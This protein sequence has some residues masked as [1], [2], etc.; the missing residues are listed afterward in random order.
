ML[1]IFVPNPVSVFQDVGSQIKEIVKMEPDVLG[2]YSSS[3][4]ILAKEKKIKQIEGLNPKFLIGASELIDDNSRE[5]I[6]DVF[7]VPLFDQYVCIELERISWQ[8]KEKKYYHMDVDSLIIEF[9]NDNENVSVGESG[10]I[11]CTS[12]FN[13]SMPLIRYA[14][15]DIGAQVDD[16]CPC[17]RTLPLMK[18]IEGRRDSLIILPNG[19]VVSP[20]TFTVAMSMFKHYHRFDQFRIIQR[21]LD[22][23]DIYVKLKDDDFRDIV[24]KD[25]ENFFRNT[26]FFDLES[27]QFNINFVD[28]IP[29]ERTGKLMMVKSEVIK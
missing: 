17:E 7:N 25:F 24:E 12:L 19:K 4:Y 1:N 21:K 22:E 13:F 11:V 2:G 14:I 5:F 28:S 29:L 18:M 8:C 27:V 20:R 16:E 23:F 10:E 6:E 26:I 3:L 9:V 15:G